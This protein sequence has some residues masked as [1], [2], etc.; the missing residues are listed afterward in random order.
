MRVFA[1][2]KINL[3]LHIQK[4]LDN[5]YHHL[6]SLVTFCNV[7]DH[8]EI[9]EAQGF[10]F[11]IDG[12]FAAAFG[13][14]DLDVSAQSSNLVV[15][16]AWRL[17]Q[18]A[19]RAPNVDIRLTKNLPLGGGIGGG[20][21]DAAAVIWGLCSLWDI[22]HDAPYMDELFLSL[23]ADVPVCFRGR[24][25][26]V[27]GIGEQLKDVPALPEMPII[28]VHPGKACSTPDI[29]RSYQ[30]GFQDMV[31]MPR[32]FEHQD[33]L[34]GFLKRCDNVLTQAAVQ[35]VPD[36]ENVLMAMGAQNGCD[37]ARMSGSGST[38]FGVFKDAQSA[39]NAAVAI[40]QANP[41]W[42]VRDG[43]AGGFARY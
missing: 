32:S 37:L 4:K 11:E 18:H 17:A 16:A 15:K 5:G 6:D 24:D 36:I 10:S 9:K 27:Q 3:Y 34:V 1:P 12:P 41:D 40:A 35:H 33:D 19:G 42:W 38:C 21:S 22:P 30:R 14:R 23:G 39:K 31:A 13:R 29:F 43:V 8:L 25:T 28:L 26:R 20:S 7:G 2:A